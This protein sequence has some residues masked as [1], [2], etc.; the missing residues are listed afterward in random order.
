VKAVTVVLAVVALRAAGCGADGL[1][2][3]VTVRSD[4]RVGPLRF[5]RSARAQ[6]VAFAGKPTS[7]ARD[8]LGP[9]LPRVDAL[10]YGCHHTSQ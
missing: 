1:P 3:R 8:R 6:V 9:R 7:E 2:A 10:Y 5:N 4:G